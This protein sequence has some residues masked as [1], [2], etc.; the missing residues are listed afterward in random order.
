MTTVLNINI[1]D[2]SNQLIKEL[3]NRFDKTTQIEIRI[4]TQEQSVELLSETQ[5][6]QIIALIDWTKELYTDILAPC[7]A[8]LAKMPI[9]NIYLFHDKLSEKLYHLD[10]KAHIAEYVAKDPDHFLSVDDFLYVR[11]A[12]V[13]EGQFYYENVL[14]NPSEMPFEI[15]FEP[16]LSL[17]SDAYKVKTGKKFDYFPV[18]NYETGS[19]QE[20]R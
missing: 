3:K 6:W 8:A 5:F 13:A 15:A 10:T 11:C 14:K 1:N 12:V 20:N 18:F 9:A 7:V 17:A 16:L 2:L 4:D 19:N